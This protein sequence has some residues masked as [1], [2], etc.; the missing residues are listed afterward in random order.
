[1]LCIG[2]KTSRSAEGTKLHAELFRM[3][4]TRS[5]ECAQ[6]QQGLKTSETCDKRRANNAIAMNNRYP[7]FYFEWLWEMKCKA[8]RDSVE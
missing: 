3:S 1:L 8:R 7:D 4:N 5:G 2:E 6:E